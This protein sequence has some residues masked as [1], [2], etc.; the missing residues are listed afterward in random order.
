MNNTIIDFFL[1]NY[2]TCFLFTIFSYILCDFKLF[3]SLLSFFYIYLVC[4]L[5]HRLLH[6]ELLYYNIFS[7]SHVFH[8]SNHSLIAYILNYIMEFL[9]ILDNI[10]L[11]FIYNIFGMDIYYI[12]K[13]IIIF[14]WIIYTTVHNI[15]YGYFKVN[16]YHLKHH[17]EPLSNIGPDIFDYLF[18]TKNKDTSNHENIDHYIPNIIGAFSIVYLLKSFYL[19]NSFNQTLLFYLF[20]ILFIVFNLFL[21]IACINIVYNETMEIIDKDLKTFLNS[22]K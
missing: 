5:G 11:R 8:H 22:K 6:E 16:E 4:Y 3:L 1:L 21:T 12:N 2:K 9:F 15:N 14:L 10:V 19:Q 7:I 20:I 18:S 17:D 13:W